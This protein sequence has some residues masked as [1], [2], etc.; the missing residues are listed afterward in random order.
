MGGIALILIISGLGFIIFAT[1]TQYQ[2]SEHVQATNYAHATVFAQ[3][4]VRGHAQATA[5]VFA[6][7][8]ANIYA[9]ATATNGVSVTQ[10]AITDNVSATATAYNDTFTQ[11][12]SGTATLSDP[13][14]DNS[15]NNNW[16]TTS[17]AKASGCAFNNGT[18]HVIERQKGSFQPCLATATSFS[19]FAYEVQM[20]VDTGTQGGIVFRADGS[21]NSFYLFRIGVDG[22]Y[23]LD[24]YK[25]GTA[26]STF[27]NGYSAA[28]TPG[29]G[30]QNT[31]G[32]IA[33][34]N[35]LDLYVNQ[36]YVASVT[37]S[38]LTSGEIGVASYDESVPTE[39][40]FSNAQ[41]WDLTGSTTPTPTPTSSGSTTPTPTPTPTST[42]AG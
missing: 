42:P 39:I 24:L 38:T 33:V 31:I 18:Y 19:D 14:S 30:Q 4:T 22:S 28:I 3:G 21:Q 6:T 8:N 11:D 35:T 16:D 5:N 27:A 15:N 20:T 32:V 41:V 7:A 25:N 2:R 40:E 26:T 17:G 23:F 37:D 1:T 36:Q 9:S 12:T 29:L 13:L 34:Q 10:T